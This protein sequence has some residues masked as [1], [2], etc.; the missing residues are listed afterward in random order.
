[1]EAILAEFPQYKL[2]PADDPHNYKCPDPADDPVTYLCKD[3]VKRH[4]LPDQETIVR[5]EPPNVCKLS[6]DNTLRAAPIPIELQDLSWMEERCLSPIVAFQ[7]Y[8]LVPFGL[9]AR[10]GQVIHIPCNVSS[11]LQLL[12]PR[13]VP[14]NVEVVLL[15][16]TSHTNKLKN[17]ILGHYTKVNMGHIFDAFCALQQAKHPA[18]VQV[19]W[20]D[21]CPKSGIFRHPELG[22]DCVTFDLY[23]HVPHHRT[24]KVEDGYESIQSMIH[25]GMLPANS[26]VSPLDELLPKQARSSYRA[27][28]AGPGHADLNKD[29]HLRRRNLR[30]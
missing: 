22:S 27:A 23:N 4:Y 17:L 18:F 26:D 20:P 3:C 8:V 14:S 2:D 6:L 24:D 21:T 28:A 1:M 19:E 25:A 29:V 12:A 30:Y 11:T 13:M 10:Q 15:V 7:T 16:R 9:H 5:R